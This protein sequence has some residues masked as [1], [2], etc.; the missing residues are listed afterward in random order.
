MSKTNQSDVSQELIAMLPTLVHRLQRHPNG[1]YEAR[2]D[3][4]GGS[5]QGY[6]VLRLRRVE[7]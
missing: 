2:Q 7:E 1:Y 4:T 6:Y 5:L 3:L